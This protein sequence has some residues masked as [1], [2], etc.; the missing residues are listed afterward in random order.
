MAN[1][2]R[3]K[4]T[5]KKSRKNEEADKVVKIFGFFKRKTHFFL[6]L[7]LKENNSRRQSKVFSISEMKNCHYSMSL[8][9]WV[10]FLT[11]HILL[12]G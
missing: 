4:M 10:L 1:T 8:Y 6:I 5:R 2:D 3:D 7:F 12:I 11:E 9:K